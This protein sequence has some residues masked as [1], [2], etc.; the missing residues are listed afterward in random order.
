VILKEV[1]MMSGS[2]ARGRRE[3]RWADTVKAV[4]RAAVALTEALAVLPS[5]PPDARAAKALRSA[6]GRISAEAGSLKRVLG[7]GVRQD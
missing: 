5:G 6:V 4:E 7:V 3:P 1:L 2:Q